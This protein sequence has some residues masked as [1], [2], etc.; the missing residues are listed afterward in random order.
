[1]KRKKI[2]IR[3]SCCM[4]V[5][6]EH[7]WKWTAW[8]CS[9]WQYFKYNYGW[10]N[11]ILV[12]EDDK[13]RLCLCRTILIGELRIDIRRR[14]KLKKKYFCKEEVKYGEEKNNGR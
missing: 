12:Y 4:Y 14:E 13:E 7:R 2:K 10:Y 3:W 9:K 1:M 6:H 8:L 11:K 5:R